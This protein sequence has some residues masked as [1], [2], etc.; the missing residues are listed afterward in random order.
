MVTEKTEFGQYLTIKLQNKCRQNWLPTTFKLI[1]DK[2][3][4]SIFDF[5]RAEEATLCR[6]EF[7]AKMQTIILRLRTHF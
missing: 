7:D 1:L 6:I 3:N 4:R 5:K 2:L